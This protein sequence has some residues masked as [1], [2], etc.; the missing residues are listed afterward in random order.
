MPK[1]NR[2]FAAYSLGALFN[3]HS[4]SDRYSHNPSLRR[5]RQTVDDIQPSLLE[6]VGFLLCNSRSE[7]TVRN[8]PPDATLS[9]ESTEHHDHQGSQDETLR[10]EHRTIAITIFAWVLAPLSEGARY[11]RW[12]ASRCGLDAYR[13]SCKSTRC[14]CFVVA[15]DRAFLRCFLDETSK[16]LTPAGLVAARRLHHRPHPVHAA[17]SGHRFGAAGL[18]HT[19]YHRPERLLGGHCEGRRVACGEPSPGGGV[20]GLSRPFSLPAVAEQVTEAIVTSEQRKIVRCRQRGVAQI[21]CR[22][23]RAGESQVAEEMRVVVG[24]RSSATTTIGMWI[25]C[26]RLNTSTARGSASQK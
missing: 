5:Q 10:G 16:G 25:T 17:L 20:A 4:R 2:Q 11:Q 21:A 26:V 24:A 7:T 19:I 3:G 6:A 9:G 13:S 18:L 8:W 12:R 14:K 22:N 15:A 1:R 23:G